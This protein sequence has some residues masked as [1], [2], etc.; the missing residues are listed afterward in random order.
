MYTLNQILATF[1]ALGSAH[2]QV[3]EFGYGEVEDIPN[4]PEY[5]LM[6]V[7]L[8][9]S[10]VNDNMANHQFSVLILDMVDEDEGNKLEV[11]SDTKLMAFDLVA[12]LRNPTFDDDFNLLPNVTFTEIRDR[13]PDH[14]AGWQVSLTIEQFYPADRAA[15]PSSYV[16][17]GG[18][19]PT[20]DV[21]IKDQTGAIIGYVSAGGIYIVPGITELDG[22]SLAIGDSQ[23]SVVN[24]MLDGGSL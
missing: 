13:T 3:R 24:G 22:G 21:T 4:E 15:V 17:I 16:P 9:D 7:T 18:V 1:Q 5:P 14:V 8:L 10:S 20:T 11:L 12:Q 6:Y 19:K 2:K 23:F